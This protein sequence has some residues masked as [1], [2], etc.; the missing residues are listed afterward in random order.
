MQLTDSM[1]IAASGM[2]AQSDRLRIISENIANAD[3][4]GQIPGSDPYRRKM[5]VFKTV[6]DKEMGLETVRVAKRTTDKSN[7]IR[8]YEPHHPAADAEGYVLYPNVNTIVEAVDMKEARRAY[9]ANL[10]V[11]EVSKAMV[12]RTLELLR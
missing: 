10:G 2:R 12:S 9:E 1:K 3:S 11:I 6:L 5:V 7:F 8:K 4:T